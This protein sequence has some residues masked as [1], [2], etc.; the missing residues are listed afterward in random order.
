MQLA[1]Q[2]WNNLENFNANNEITENCG[3]SVTSKVIKFFLVIGN[4]K[5]LK[6]GHSCYLS[7]NSM[8]DL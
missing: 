8:C 1:L 3:I 5:S 2:I 7:L 4:I 6:V